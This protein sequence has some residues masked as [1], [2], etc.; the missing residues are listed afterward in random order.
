MYS[1]AV[2]GDTGMKEY[3]LAQSG[4]KSQADQGT[5]GLLLHGALCM[6][7]STSLRS[8]LRLVFTK[9]CRKKG[10]QYIKSCLRMR[11]RP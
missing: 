7:T 3:L 10:L 5:A 8:D 4:W 11:E 1:C 6:S 9:L 2:C